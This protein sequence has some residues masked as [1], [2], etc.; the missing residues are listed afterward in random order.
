LA[1]SRKFT[2]TFTAFKYGAFERKKK[3]M[4]YEG[5]GFLNLSG[6]PREGIHS[7]AFYRAVLAARPLFHCGHPFWEIAVDQFTV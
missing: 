1:F 5:D 3:R 6:V 4:L 7:I 2:D